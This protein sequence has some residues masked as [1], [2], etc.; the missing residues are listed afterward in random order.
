MSDWPHSKGYWGA[1]NKVPDEG[2]L[3]LAADIHPKTEQ[4]LLWT[5]VDFDGEVPMGEDKSFKLRTKLRDIHND[6]SVDDR[7][8]VGQKIPN[9]YEVG[10]IFKTGDIQEIAGL[11]RKVEKVIGRPHDYFL[12]EPAAWGD[13]QNKSSD[14]VAAQFVKLGFDP[15]KASKEL[16]GGILKVKQFF[17]IYDFVEDK[18]YQNPRLMTC[19]NLERVRWERKNYH[20]PRPP[21]GQDMPIKQKPVDKDDHMMENERRIVQYVLDHELSI[22]TEKSEDVFVLP[23]GT[24]IQLQQSTF[25]A[26]MGE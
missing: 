12:L 11:A 25:D 16:T 19:E 24:E 18:E 21:K 8:E 22:I 3:V 23:D 15:I 14:N 4:A 17:K 2:V 10:E 6:A 20:Y 7:Y 1:A 26:N 9:L 13:D 5:W